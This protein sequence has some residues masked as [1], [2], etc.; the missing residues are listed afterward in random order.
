MKRAGKR[1]R[2]VGLRASRMSF[3][4]WRISQESWRRASG[5]L[6]SVL[7]AGV[8]SAEDGKDGTGLGVQGSLGD[9]RQ[10]RNSK[11]RVRVVLS[12]ADLIHVPSSCERIR[13]SFFPLIGLEPALGSAAKGPGAHGL[14]L[15]VT[16]S[17]C[18]AGKSM[19]R[20]MYSHVQFC[21]YGGV[22]DCNDA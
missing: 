11:A 5:G 13:T 3:C 21:N 12:R 22:Y 1:G 16:L 4:G 19:V 8:C 20:I 2:A 17:P 14:K 7:R 6:S 15:R 18:N 9:R 10:Y